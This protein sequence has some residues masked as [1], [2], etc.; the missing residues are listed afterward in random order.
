M[1]RELAHATRR[2][3][4]SGAIACL[5]AMACA[6]CSLLPG[7]SADE[8]VDIFSASNLDQELLKSMLP[9]AEQYVTLYIEDK[10]IARWLLPT[11]VVFGRRAERLRLEVESTLTKQC[12]DKAGHPQYLR[13]TDAAAP[14]P[15]NSPS[16]SKVFTVDIAQ[17]Y[18]YR[19]A[20]DPGVLNMEMLLNDEGYDS[21]SNEFREAWYGCMDEAAEAVRGALG[22]AKHNPED[23]PPATPERKLTSELNRLMVDT[24][25]EPLRSAAQQ[26]RECMSPLGIADLS[27]EPAMNGGRG[28]VPESLREQWQWRIIGQPTADEVRVAVHDAQC[29]EQSKWTELYYDADWQ[30]SYDLMRDKQDIVSG[31]QEKQR[32]VAAALLALRS[33]IGASH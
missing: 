22:E 6:G 19:D 17:K 27:T 11:D 15:E 29:R 14:F 26:W 4:A 23:E 9:Q 8:P 10:D 2:F 20:P 7:G 16:R 33:T 30:S 21:Q 25:V 3:L 24:S 12:M 18:G 13:S 1:T 28:M 32:Q 5:C 31:I